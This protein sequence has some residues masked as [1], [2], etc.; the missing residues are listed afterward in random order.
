MAELKDVNPDLAAT[1]DQ[2]IRGSIVQSTELRQTMKD[3]TRTR[4]AQQ[5]QHQRRA[6]KNQRLKTG[7]VL[8]VA[9]GRAMVRKREDEELRKA[10]RLIERAERIMK[11]RA[12]RFFSE[13]AKKARK[14]RMDGILDPL[15]IID[16]IDGGRSV[17]RDGK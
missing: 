4:Y 15:Y 3:L 16:S 11:N 5:V 14:W 1:I 2:F 13:A 6:L 9:D 8:T 17:R 7:G 10:Q 12:K